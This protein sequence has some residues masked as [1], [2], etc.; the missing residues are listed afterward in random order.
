MSV[1]LGMSGRS[2]VISFSTCIA[3]VSLIDYINS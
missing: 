1:C 2:E 3:K